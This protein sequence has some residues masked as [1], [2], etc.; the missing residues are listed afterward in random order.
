LTRE[1]IFRSAEASDYNGYV[2]NSRTHLI[3]TEFGIQQ[4]Y[5]N[6]FSGTT[7][8]R[9]AM[10]VSDTLNVTIRDMTGR[11]VIAWDGA[12]E[13]GYIPIVWGAS[14]SPAGIYLCTATA[15]GKNASIQMILA[16]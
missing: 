6:P 10:P 13:A 16:K 2:L 9:V 3:P 14:D 8:I 5:P 11:Q 12:Y 7:T 15:F 4:N 1:G